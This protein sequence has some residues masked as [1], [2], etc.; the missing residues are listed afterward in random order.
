MLTNVKQQEKQDNKKQF[1]SVAWYDRKGIN[2]LQNF[3][4]YLGNILYAKVSQWISF[5]ILW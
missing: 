2:Q 3:D 4:A 5:D 1:D